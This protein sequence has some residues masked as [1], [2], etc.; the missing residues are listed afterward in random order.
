MNEF[1]KKE[2]GNLG[3]ELAVRFLERKGY[4][5][6]QRNYLKKWGEIDIVAK[7]RDWTHFIEV[8]TFSWETYLLPED[9]V[10]SEKLKRLHRA[11]ETYIEEFHVKGEIQVDI[12]SVRLHLKDKKAHCRMIENVL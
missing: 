9:N 5:V 3:E 11:I 8:K 2:V 12:V 7:R 1:T 4:T 6:V 10:H